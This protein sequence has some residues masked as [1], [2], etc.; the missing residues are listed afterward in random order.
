MRR[1]GLIPLPPGFGENNNSC[2]SFTEF[3]ENGLPVNFQALALVASKS[4]SIRFF[5]DLSSSTSMFAPVNSMS[6][7]AA[8]TSISNAHTLFKLP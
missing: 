2:F 4:F 8:T 5:K 3:I 1:F 6:Q 7:R